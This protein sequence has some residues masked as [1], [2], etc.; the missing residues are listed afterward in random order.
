[1]GR[2]KADDPKVRV[3]VW[4]HNST[5]ELNGGIENS[6]KKVITYLEAEASKKK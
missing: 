1:M 3:D 4:V 5:I 6:K 2:K